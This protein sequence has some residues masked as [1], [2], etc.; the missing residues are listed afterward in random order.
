MKENH[1]A[2]FDLVLK[3]ETSI[4]TAVSSFEG[5]VTEWEYLFLENFFKNS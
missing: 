1:T 2:M 3:H 5:Y 4:L